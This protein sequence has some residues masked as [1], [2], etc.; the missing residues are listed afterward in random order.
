MISGEFRWE[1]WR[2]LLRIEIFRNYK[3]QTKSASR[4]IRARRPNSLV[5]NTVGIEQRS[6]AP[7]KVVNMIARIKS[8]KRVSFGAGASPP[9]RLVEELRGSCPPDDVWDPLY[10]ER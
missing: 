9:R 8:Q 5:G 6:S 1:I 2:D 3:I 4:S 10:C 7:K